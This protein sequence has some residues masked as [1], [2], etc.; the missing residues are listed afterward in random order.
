MAL[1]FK[2]REDFFKEIIYLK[3]MNEYS[4]LDAMIEYQNKYDLDQ[5]YI[6]NN[7]M[8]PNLYLLLE[9]EAKKMNLL[10]PNKSN[11]FDEL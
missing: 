1:E 4:L 7:L 8:T 6:V 2:N 11:R 10:K 9:A 5:E 3:K